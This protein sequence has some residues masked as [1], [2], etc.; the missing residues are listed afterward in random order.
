MS[1]IKFFSGAAR[2]GHGRDTEVDVLGLKLSIRKE[3]ALP[4]PLDG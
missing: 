3:P 4:H 1:Q 2:E